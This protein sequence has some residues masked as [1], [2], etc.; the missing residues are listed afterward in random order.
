MGP[1]W[2]LFK[3]VHF[4]SQLYRMLVWLFGV[5]FASLLSGCMLEKKGSHLDSSGLK[6]LSLLCVFMF[7]RL[8]HWVLCP[9]VICFGTLAWFLTCL[10]AIEQSSSADDFF[11]ISRLRVCDRSE[12]KWTG[13]P[14]Y[15][16]L[17]WYRYWQRFKV[18]QC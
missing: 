3:L 10:G 18:S 1:H 7:V 12:C 15:L 14:N 16:K 5:V 11:A 8:Y 6:H 2:L 9:G 4:I 17:T 13:I